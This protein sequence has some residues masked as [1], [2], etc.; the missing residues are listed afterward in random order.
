VPTAAT[1]S[2]TS[3]LRPVHELGYTPLAGSQIRYNLLA[4]DQLLA[5]LNFGASAR[6]T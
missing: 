3:L 6:D 5:L 4:G 1:D 2:Q